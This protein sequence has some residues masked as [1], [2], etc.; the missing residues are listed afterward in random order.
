[1]TR[2]NK[3]VANDFYSEH[4]GKPFFG[5]LCSFMESDVVTG[6]EIINEGA[7]DKWRNLI[8]PTNSLEAK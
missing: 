7:V 8:G 2:M 5:D 6:I 3:Q 1:M 4:R